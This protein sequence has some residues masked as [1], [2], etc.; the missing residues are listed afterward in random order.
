MYVLPLLF[1]ATVAANLLKNYIPFLEYFDDFLAVSL[2]TLAILNILYFEA[3]KKKSVVRKLDI[4]I[5]SVIILL[6]VYVGVMNLNPKFKNTP[7]LQLYTL[8]AELKFIMIYWGGSI[9]FLNSSLNKIKKIYFVKQIK[10]IT[11]LFI[12]LCYISFILDLKF[13]FMQH[14]EE[15][16][17]ITSVAYGFEHPAQFAVVLIAFTVMNIITN[18]FYYNKLSYLYAV[19][20]FPLMLTAG[21]NAS[22]AF[23]ACLILILFFIKRFK[24]IPVIFYIIIAVMFVTISWQRIVDQFLTDN[25]QARGLLMRTAFKIASDY[26]PL[27]SGLGTFGSNASKLNYSQLYYEYG[28]SNVWGLSKEYPAFITDS[29]WAMVIAEMGAIGILIII[30]LIF[31][32]GKNITI[33]IKEIKSNKL[34][35]FILYIYLIITSPVDS[36]FTSN[37]L[38]VLMI[39]TIFFVRIGQSCNSMK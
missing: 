18:Y 39:S 9:V 24:R 10:Y 26:F 12:I 14:F 2:F 11:Y 37:S 17:G 16:F 28:L 29:Y 13:S 33:D 27:G 19:F 22:I 35:F 30:F 25:T 3:I 32:L 20:S 34:L 21:R 38:A 36:I 4:I 6:F 23:L 5:I 15:R 7:V 31:L 1:I 8:F